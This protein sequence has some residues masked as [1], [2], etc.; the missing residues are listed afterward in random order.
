AETHIGQ[1]I[2]EPRALAAAWDKPQTE[3]YAEPAPTG[4]ESRGYLT[5]LSSGTLETVTEWDGHGFSRNGTA[6]IG[7]F[8]DSAQTRIRC[9]IPRDGTRHT[10]LAGCM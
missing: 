8:A 3:A 4:V 2:A 6:R 9:W 5:V 7:R 10:L 1:V